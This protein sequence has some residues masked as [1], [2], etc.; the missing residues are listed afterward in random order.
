[1]LYDN[2]LPLAH[3]VSHAVFSLGLCKEAAFLKITVLQNH[4]WTSPTLAIDGSLATPSNRY[5][6]AG[7]NRVYSQAAWHAPGPGLSHAQICSEVPSWVTQVRCCNGLCRGATRPPPTSICEV[8]PFS[9]GQ[10]LNFCKFGPF[11][12][13][14][15]L[16][17]RHELHSEMLRTSPPGAPPITTHSSMQ[18]SKEL[19]RWQGYCQCNRNSSCPSFP[20]QQDHVQ[21]Q[22]RCQRERN[23]L[24]KGSYNMFPTV[25]RCFYFSCC[26]LL[27]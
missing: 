21:H 22:D 13:L 16:C 27:N 15:K 4:Q 7:S 18:L 3:P 19:L 6:T 11:L 23:A 2:I 12:F 20:L 1:M 10:Q 14:F 25:C 26:L 8:P 5:L 9:A 17:F 24:Y